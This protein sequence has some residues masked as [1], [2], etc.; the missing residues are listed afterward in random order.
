MKVVITSNGAGLDAA[1]SPVFGRCPTYNFVDVDTMECESVENPA[2][3]ASG[4][5]GI[6]AAQ[7][8][9]EQGAQAV[10]T[11][12]MG[13][14][15]YGVL[16]ASGKE[17]YLFGGGTVRQAVEAFKAGQLQAMMGASVPAHSGMGRGMRRRMG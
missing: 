5:A 6:Q 4:G 11:G 7:F 12:N 15:A 16:Q 10:V 14:N 3:G 13:P 17:V 8:V 1:T 9:L 2:L